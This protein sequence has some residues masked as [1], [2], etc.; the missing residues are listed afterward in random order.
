M[1]GEVRLI[2][3]RVP[4]SLPDRVVAWPVAPSTPFLSPLVEILPVQ[5]FVYEFALA[6]GH[7]PGK[8]RASTPITLTEDGHPLEEEE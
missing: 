1:K 7:P 8:F 6:K 2:T 4:P 3:S 5:F